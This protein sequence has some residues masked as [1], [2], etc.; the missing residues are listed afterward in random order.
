M[1]TRTNN[2]TDSRDAGLDMAR[3]ALQTLS[4]NSRLGL[5]LPIPMVILSFWAF[6]RFEA[7]WYFDPFL[8]GIALVFLAGQLFAWMQHRIF[9]RGA[10]KVSKALDA[11]SFLPRGLTPV[12]ESLRLLPN[13][14]FRDLMLRVIRPLQAGNFS[15][16]Q[17]LLDSA[18]N[19][20]NVHENR[21]MGQHVTVNRIIL[22]LGF[23]GTLIGLLWTFPP[24]KDAM[25]S[26]TGSEG[27]F[28]F[29]SHIA[30]ALDGDRFAI[31]ATLIATG[32]SLLIELVTIQILERSFAQFEEV[33]SLSEEW[34]M[35]T[36]PTPEPGSNG[37]TAPERVET[38][39]LEMQ[40][41]LGELAEVVRRTSRRIEDVRE[42]QDALERRFVRK[43]DLS[44]EG[45]I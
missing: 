29:V 28:K 27:Q 7:H 37:S 21:R 25:L 39:Q 22:K 36:V 31:F 17:S 14:H 11:L 41:N 26:L 18:A 38:L 34:V 5:W 3:T 12:A 9:L 10:R 32:L 6:G 45:R 33:N 16:A 8:G 44:R 13:S 35:S 2:T 42:M 24:M 40:R 43:D 30:A 1:R 20:R 4:R 23:L 15:L 19:R